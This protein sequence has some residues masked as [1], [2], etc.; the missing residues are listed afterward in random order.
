VGPKAGCLLVLDCILPLHLDEFPPLL[1][2]LH[3]QRK[4][5]MQKRLEIAQHVHTQE[6]NP[7]AR[8]RAHHT[9]TD[10]GGWWVLLET[11]CSCGRSGSF[12][13]TMRVHS[14][15]RSNRS[16][17]PQTNGANRMRPPFAQGSSQQSAPHGSDLLLA[18]LLGSG[19][20]LRLA[21]DDDGALLPSAG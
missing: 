7:R 18:L 4:E 5:I 20:P 1:V 16:C 9:Q 21:L 13:E 6:A 10:V 12:E 2:T 14:L 17:G 8:A 15:R 19:C 3:L 11:L